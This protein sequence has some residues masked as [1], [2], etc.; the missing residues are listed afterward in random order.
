MDIKLNKQKSSQTFWK[1]L[2]IPFLA[3]LALLSWGFSSPIGSSPDDNFHLASIWCGQGAREGICEDIP[4]IKDAKL[5]PASLLTSTCYAYQPETSG[6]CQ[7]NS[8]KDN[9]ELV[10][11]GPGNFEGL[12]PPVFYWVMSFF[13]GPDAGLSVM[14]MRIFNS[15]LF[16]GVITATF[17]LVP[18][19]IKR[20][21]FWGSIISSVPL[22]L[23]IIPSTNPSSW[24]VISATTLWALMYGFFISHN[25]KERLI[26]GSL[27]LFSA[28]IGAGARADSAI[29]NIIAVVVAIVLT[30]NFKAKPRIISVGLII[31]IIFMSLLFYFSAGQSLAASSGLVANSGSGGIEGKVYLFVVN[32]LQVPMIWVG[33]LG[34]WGLGWLDTP[35]PFI[36]QTFSFTIFA[37]LAFW[38][39]GLKQ[40]SKSEL[41]RKLLSVS[42]VFMALYL[43]PTVV[44]VQTGAMAGGYFQPRYI[45]PLVI[46]FISLLLLGSK[47]RSDTQFLTRPQN[48]AIVLGLSLANTFA[49]HTNIRRYVT[50]I[51][52]GSW[53]LNENVEWWWGIPLQPLTIWVIGSLSFTGVL[54]LAFP[55]TRAHKK[56]LFRTIPGGLA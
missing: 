26:L 17:F 36:V 38:G 1:L 14:L 44:L 9:S 12:Y 2:F 21:V 11:L 34:S 18:Q 49:L 55:I 29:F 7:V 20:P 27:A 53:N 50:G 24:A 37:G 51:D 16:V 48:L 35:L 32:L 6:I 8:N 25:T 52:V 28:L 23:F 39:L 41:M 54:L 46:I 3:F 31:L 43:Y 13:V 45:L 33:V 40:I 4:G 5:V 15:A 47:E 56:K 22:A 19:R 42:L 30:I 10:K